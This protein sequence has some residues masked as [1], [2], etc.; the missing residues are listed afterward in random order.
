MGKVAAR[1]GRDPEAR[2]AAICALA[3]A[4]SAAAIPSAAL[5][6][7]LLRILILATLQKN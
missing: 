7:E 6:A 5:P 2:N 3:R 1:T 4:S